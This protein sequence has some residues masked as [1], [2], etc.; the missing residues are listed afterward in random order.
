M[1]KIKNFC[2]KTRYRKEIN[3]PLSKI[4]FR[5]N[6]SGGSMTYIYEEM[7]F[8]SFLFLFCMLFMFASS[9]RHKK[10]LVDTKKKN[11]TA[12]SS[13]ITKANEGVISEN[14]TDS[15]IDAVKQKLGISEEEIAHSKL[16]AFICEWYGVPYKYGGC[17]KAGIDCSC[18]T[19]VLVERVYGK[20]V[21]RT[22]DGIYNECH[23]ILPNEMK[24]GDLVFFKINANRVSHVG[25]YLKDKLF[26]HASTSKG[27]II[28][29][30]NEVYYK[31]YFHSG[32]HLKE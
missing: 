31:T 20:K 26:V 13:N 17:Q 11:V 4:A 7:R 19:S 9:C 5:Y 3:N 23:K 8:Y 25:V 10:H 18:F 32:G 27:V 2:C 12:K 29:S 30:M 24:E 16:Y 28:S 15:S 1:L 14:K 22:A 21:E 6:K